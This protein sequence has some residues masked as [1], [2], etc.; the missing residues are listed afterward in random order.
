MIRLKKLTILVGIAV[1]A[2][3]FWGTLPPLC[4]AAQ[5]T[6]VIDAAHGGDDRGVQLSRSV[7][8][9]DVTLA[10][11]KII[12]DI[13]SRSKDIGAVL[14]RSDDRTLSLDARKNIIRN[15]GADF[16]VSIHVNAGFG[17]RAAGYE[18]YV[19]GSGLAR[20][21][22]GDPE[23]VIDEL[24]EITY[25]NNSIRFSNIADREL[26]RVFL[27]E[28]RGVRPAPVAILNSI[29]MPGVLIELGF[30]S[31]VRN[32]DGL[33]EG[34]TQEEAAKMIAEAIR[35]YFGVPPS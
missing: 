6:V 12:E 25:L 1:L 24:L 34:R 16:L 13:L 21:K 15:A 20:D 19:P 29:S 27:R 31:N 33:L 22:N 9:K 8:E 5:F 17:T 32:R 23:T 11:A 35:L 18:I 2:T 10:I 7:S 28:G 30:A 3:L 26:G 4:K 14:T